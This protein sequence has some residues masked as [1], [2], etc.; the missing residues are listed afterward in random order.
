MANPNNPVFASSPIPPPFLNLPWGELR[1]GNQV[2]LSI[3]AIQFLQELWAAIQGQDG[4]LDQILTLAFSP[5]LTG[6]TAQGLID[7]LATQYAQEAIPPQDTGALIAAIQ[8]MAL[9]VQAPPRFP[10][11]AVAPV[12]FAQTASVTVANTVTET[13]L[14]GAGVGSL[15]APASSLSIGSRM[16]MRASGAHSAT[17]GS[18]LRIR[19]YLGSTLVLDTG[20]VGVGASSAQFWQ[21]QGDLTVRTLGAPGSVIAEGVVQES[22]TP[23]GFFGMANTTPI[24]LDTTVDQTFSLTAQWGT[25]AAGN[26]ISAAILDFQI[27][28][29]SS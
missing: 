18:T 8:D 9:T 20:A 11:A 24:A 25:A 5:G 1:G 21:F 3:P 12:S 4:V 23:V 7:Q 6:A 29:P 2:F 17:G 28:P 13:T 16:A 19:A 27:I 26:T 10:A 22:A 14:V 15:V